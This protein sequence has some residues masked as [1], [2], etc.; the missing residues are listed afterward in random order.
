MNV[1]ETIIAQAAP[2][3]VDQTAIPPV[4]PAAPPAALEPNKEEAM[5]PKLAIIARKERALV[6]KQQEF[7]KQQQEWQK[8]R[9]A[10]K[11]ELEAERSKRS[12]WKEDP[13]K[14]LEEL[15]W[16]YDRLTERKINGGGLTPK[17]LEKK[18]EERFKS[19]EERMAEEKAT[20]EKAQQEAQE[21]Q[22]QKIIDDFK[23]DLKGHL[24][25]NAEKYKLSNLFDN[26]AELLYQTIDAY[27]EANG[28]IL[29]NEEASDL[30]EKYFVKL[31]EDAQK[32]LTPKEQA[33][34]DEEKKSLGVVDKKP[35]QTTLT[36]DMNNVAGASFLS[37]KTEEDRMRR[38]M[39][40]LDGNR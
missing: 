37:P 1:A 12:L 6:Q 13:D 32:A 22:Q 35:T 9:E 5:S 16:D 14:A 15:G 36:N 38:A 11:A 7:L 39:A 31:Y 28:K 33:K 4:D 23:E 29:S 21:K 3:P 24:K 34:L 30:V 2:A 27:Y 20:L 19:Y 26:D 10:M 18:M 40:A 8:E 17:D 25:T